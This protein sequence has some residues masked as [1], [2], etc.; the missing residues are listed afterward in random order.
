MTPDEVAIAFRKLV[1]CSHVHGYRGGS[2]EVSTTRLSDFKCRR[3]E[4]NTS[5][6]KLTSR[7]GDSQDDPRSV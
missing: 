3:S 6:K 5:S 4:L 1:D 7:T 2:C